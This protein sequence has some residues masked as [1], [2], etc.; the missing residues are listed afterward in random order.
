LFSKLSNVSQFEDLVGLDFA[1]L[2]K[3]HMLKAWSPADGTVGKYWKLQ[4]EEPSRLLGEY[5]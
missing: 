5:S 4:E 1:C 3:P 2:L